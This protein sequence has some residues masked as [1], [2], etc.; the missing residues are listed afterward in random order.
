MGYFVQVFHIVGA[1][2]LANKVTA[3]VGGANKGTW[4]A[5]IMG[6]AAASLGPPVSQAA[7]YWGRKW[8]VVGLSAGSCVGCIIVSRADTIG[9]VIAGQAIGALSQGCQPTIHAIASEIL[10][11]KYRPLAQSSVNVAAA[12][13]GAI[14]LLAGGALTVNNANG[15]RVYWYIAAGMYAITAFIIFLLYNPPV[16]ELQTRYTQLEKLARLDWIGYFFLVGGLVLFSFSLTSAI[17]IYAWKSANIIAPLVIGVTMLIAFFVYEW[18]FTRTGVLHHDLFSRGRNFAIAEL[19]IFVEGMSFFASNQYYGFEIVAI[20]QQNQFKAGLYY[21]VAWFTLVIATICA[22]LYCSR[23]KSIRLPVMVAFTS[24]ALYNALMAS[25]QLSTRVNTLGYAVFLGI[26]LGIAL[27]ALVTVAQLSTPP[28]LIST[29]T[30]LMIATRSFGGT[31]GLS[32]YTAIFSSTLSDNLGQKVAAAALPLGLKPQ[33][34]GELIGGLTTGNTALLTSIPGISPTILGAAGKA[35]R[36]SYLL[37]FR[38]VWVTAGVFAALAVIGAAFLVDP[39]AEFTGHI[40]AP[41]ESEEELHRGH[42]KAS[43]QV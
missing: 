19:C 24:F 13:G 27:N 8:F 25:L 37:G 26:G 2:F 17:Q 32:I 35:V 14:G 16:R 30:G 3:V 15:F 20:Y 38:Y 36:Q 39:K 4:L 10:P 23:F 7:D 42:G 41:V 22:G 12:L 33:Y 18:R 43:G 40:D 21:T 11:R 29:T 9:V 1:G 34:L 5:S 31:V 6:I 28:E